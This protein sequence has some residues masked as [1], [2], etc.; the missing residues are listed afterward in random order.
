MSTFQQIRG[1]LYVPWWE[2]QFE[3]HVALGKPRDEQHVWV[4]V[5]SYRWLLANYPDLKGDYNMSRYS[6]TEL[7]WYDYD[8]GMSREDPLTL[9]Y[10]KDPKVAAHFKLV[11]G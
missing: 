7:P 8:W 2:P 9:F 3:Y 5:E 11:W 1:S 4:G 6:E 10:F